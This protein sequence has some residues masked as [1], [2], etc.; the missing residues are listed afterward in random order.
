MLS[1][2]EVENTRHNSTPT[3]ARGVG[4]RRGFVENFNS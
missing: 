3:N 4:A 1:I 2:I